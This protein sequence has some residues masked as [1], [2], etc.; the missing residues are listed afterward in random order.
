MPSH[1]VS[2]LIAGE[3]REIAELLETLATDRRDRFPLAHRL[4]D[5][6]S[7]HTAA[8]Q[9]LLYPAMRDIVPGGIEMADRAQVEHQA[10]RAALIV[11]ERTH[12]GQP[13]F[14]DALATIT[15]ELGAHVPVE[16]NEILPALRAVIGTDKM[17]ELGVLYLQIKENI[18]SGLQGLAPDIP[19]PEFR[20]W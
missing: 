15:A 5:A 9:Q 12:P 7:S 1:D 20:S 11:L 14:E 18:P 6:L 16:E 3:H 13:D 19:S 2:E 17:E 10:M 8:E 4:I